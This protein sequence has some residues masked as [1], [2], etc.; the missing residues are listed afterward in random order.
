MQ[1]IKIINKVVIDGEEILWEDLP[2]EK[3][4]KVAEAIQDT[5]MSHAG[6]RRA[7]A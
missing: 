4:R 1:D 3:Q 6:Y 7:T 5:M 2:P